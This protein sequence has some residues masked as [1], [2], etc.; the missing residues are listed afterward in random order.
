MRKRKDF[1][2]LEGV[3]SARLVVIAA[4]GRDTE[5]IYFE[6][7]K[8]H[9]KASNVHVEILHR[10]DNNSSPENVQCQI[11]NFM[12][13]YNIEQDDELWIVIDRDRWTAKSLAGMA[14]QCK[15][16]QN[17]HFSV[18]NP[19]FELWLLL[20]YDDVNSYNQDELSKIAANRKSSRW[21]STFLKQR[22]RDRMGR[23]QESNYDA[24]LL[25]DKASS[26]ISRAEVLD[27]VPTD[28]WPQSVGT[29]VYL[30]MRSIMDR[31]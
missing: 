1:I 9:L 15:Q 22:V 21:G 30:L 2:R 25:M 7:V 28:R 3:R 16:N 23:Y 20:H 10:E 13:E 26:A 5:N 19:C 6:A 18:S 12:D 31:D 27:A 29:R 24:N 11:R 8:Q 14:R 4:E 17:L